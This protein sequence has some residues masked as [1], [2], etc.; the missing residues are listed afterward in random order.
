V[1][2]LPARLTAAIA[3]LLLIAVAAGCGFEVQQPDLFLLT[4]TG[5]GHK[6]TLLINSGGTV[7][8]NGSHTR[9]LPDK[10]LLRARNLTGRLNRDARHRLRIPPG[11]GSVFRYRVKLQAGTIE[12]WDTAARGHP[13]L[14]ALELLALSIAQGPCGLGGSS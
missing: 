7:R 10:L 13:E 9:P 14:A 6:L 8:C 2:G 5:E 11:P 4:R 1:A 3:A 12:F